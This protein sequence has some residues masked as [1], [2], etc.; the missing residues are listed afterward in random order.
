MSYRI[1][2]LHNHNLCNIIKEDRQKYLYSVII[3]TMI[4]REEKEDKSHSSKFKNVSDSHP[5]PC[6]PSRL[7]NHAKKSKLA[8]IP[9]RRN[10]LSDKKTD[11]RWKAE[12]FIEDDLVKN[13]PL[14]KN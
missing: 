10:F 5:A 7:E 8:T 13:V 3:V 4:F 6:H 11:M 9:L 12:F 1:F 2:A 14:E